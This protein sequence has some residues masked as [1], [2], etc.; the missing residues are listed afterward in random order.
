MG[1]SADFPINAS[2]FVSVVLGI[3]ESKEN[4]HMTVL[5]Q[6]KCGVSHFDAW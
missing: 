3:V 1:H 5:C 4:F 2:T 6:T